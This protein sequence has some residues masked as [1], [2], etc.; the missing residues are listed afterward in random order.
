[1][2]DDNP[3]ALVGGTHL[4]ARL[5][6]RR[7]GEILLHQNLVTAEVLEKAEA[8]RERGESLAGALVRLGYLDEKILATAYAKQH[9]VAVVD[10]DEL[11]IDPEVIALVPENMAR[12]YVFLPIAK[13][14]RRLRVAV[15]EPSHINDIDSLMRFRPGSDIAEV[16]VSFVE[17]TALR[18]AIDLYYSKT[19]GGA[20]Q[21]THL[22]DLLER[23]RGEAAEVVTPTVEV[24]DVSQLKSAAAD[25]ALVQLVNG[26]LQDAVRQGASDIHIEPYESEF[27]VRF[28]I[29]GI[30]K[31][32]FVLPLH[33]KANVIS[34]LKIMT[35]SLDIS[36]RRVPQ[37]G[38]IRM[39]MGPKNQVDFRLSTIPLLYGE[40]AV[41]R[42][43]DQSAIS[44][45]LSKKGFGED[46]LKI[47]REAVHQPWGMV[48]VTGP[49]G[50]G[51]TTTL[52]SA[53]KEVHTRG[54]NISTVEDPVEMEMP[55]INQVAVNEPAGLTFASALRAFL[56]QDPDIIMVGEIRDFETAETAVKAA[57]TGHLVFSTLHTND[58]PSTISRLLNMG[59]E[60]F[61]VSSSLLLICAQRLVRKVCKHCAEE[62]T[63]VPEYLLSHGFSE[64]MLRGAT[65]RKGRGCDRCGDSGYKGRVGIFEVM[66]F[67]D[68]V[69]A[70]VLEGNS[71]IELG[72]LAEQQGMMR[73]RHAGLLKVRDGTTTMEEILRVTRA[74]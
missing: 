58:A 60:P 4:P 39:R 59:I 22:A 55:G 20:K 47:F 24:V 8:E 38:R 73:L 69:R 63:V 25:S 13:D 32:M 19:Q 29:D 3:K 50:S 56:R 23:V 72:R 30:L 41:L 71:S 9:G 40:K 57:L 10:M 6:G 44:L 16:D 62:V 1:M 54:E 17:D 43:L 7:V 45:D 66:P 15:A 37:D 2:A 67:T 42:V 31:D 52:Y 14:G 64:D 34:L 36:E 49:T 12:R 46:Q 33:I 51:K 48:L 65:F 61:L 74:S 27:T 11:D 35:N 68:E 21:G 53:L 26:I 18:R 28:R 70:G 5:A